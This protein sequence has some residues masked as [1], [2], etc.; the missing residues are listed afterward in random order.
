M[1]YS[2][3][4]LF[5]ITVNDNN[6]TIKKK[7]RISTTGPIMD[8]SNFISVTRGVSSSDANKQDIDNENDDDDKESKQ[9]HWASYL[10]V[11]LTPIDHQLES[12]DFKMDQQTQDN[13]AKH[14]QINM[15]RKLSRRHT[16]TNLP[17]TTTTTTTQ[18]ASQ[19]TNT[20]N[21][22]PVIINGL[23]RGQIQLECN[24]TPTSLDDS[25]SLI[26]WYKDNSMVPIYRWVK[27]FLFF[28]FVCFLL[29]FSLVLFPLLI[30]L[31]C[32]AL[33]CYPIHHLYTYSG[34]SG[35]GGKRSKK[36][37]SKQKQ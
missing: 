26:L 15:N 6:N 7:P 3:L 14:S 35:S 5:S 33:R 4:W 11:P 1:I 10:S 21:K 17:V 23:L 29:C 28:V 20:A 32:S 9:K 36:K 8:P 22:P 25:V 16:A 37:Q 13:K 24:L 30:E 31:S 18:T 19:H 2:N 34:A 27:V 12:S